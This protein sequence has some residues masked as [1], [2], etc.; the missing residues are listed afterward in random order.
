MFFV[1]RVLVRRINQLSILRFASD[2]VADSQVGFGTSNSEHTL[3]NAYDSTRSPLE[4]VSEGNAAIEVYPNIRPA[5]N[6][7]AYVN[8][9]EPLQQLVRLGVDLH[10]LEKRK[11]I[12][13]FILRLDF[14]RDMKQHL[15]CLTD[16]G[17]ATEA[18][19]EFITKNPLIFKED[20][21]NMEV[22]INYLQ[23]KQFLP[24]QIARIIY[25]NPFWLMISTKRIDRRLGFFQKTFELS[26]NDV[27][28]LTAKQPRLI[29]YNLEHVRKNTFAIKEELGFEK[30]EMKQ[31]LLSKPK[32]W[33]INEDKLMHR[34]EYVHR[35]MQLTNAEI[36]RTPEILLARDH[37]IKQR[38]GFLQFLGKAQYNPRKEL[39]VS[40]KTLV[41]GTD[42]DFV[43]EVAKS[44]MMSFNNYLKTL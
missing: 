28:L 15:R 11:G 40:P 5:F 44:D 7:A 41:E 10:K 43:I 1:S 39:Y 17:V 30:E 34:F 6:F 36:L 21:G 19:G 38:H 23:S 25:K 32:L 33:M 31:L 20:I 14:E 27:R 24:E 3:Q 35:K 26:G 18:L 16:V 29:T 42:Q 37:R 9:S 22:R 8:K 4:P 2:A 12:P 13:Q